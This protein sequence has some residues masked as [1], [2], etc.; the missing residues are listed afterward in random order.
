MFLKKLNTIFILM[1]LMISGTV[2]AQSAKQVL[3]RASQVI[4]GRS[5]ASA[6]FRI[7]GN[8][9]GNTSG[10]I[11]IKGRKFH[12]TTPQAIIWFNGK[13]EWTYMKKNDEV[14]VNNPTEAQLQ[15]INPYNFINMYRNG[16]RYTMNSK[17][18]NYVVHLT[19]IGKRSVPEMYIT[20]KK[21]SY[22][23]SQVRMRQGNSWNTIS[24]SNFRT[25]QLSNSIFTFNSNEFPKAEV[26]DLR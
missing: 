21:G 14:N 4:S 24:I 1:F 10:T 5:G 9:Y 16:Y 13:T 18:H 23:L 8:K 25:K 11:A 17:G 15:K 12:A 2:S 19:A 26:I 3:D 20:V 6:N 7:S 22:Y